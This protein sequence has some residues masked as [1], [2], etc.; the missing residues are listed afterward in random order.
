M[1][2]YTRSKIY[3]S[4]SNADGTETGTT[5][6]TQTTDSGEYNFQPLEVYAQVTQEQNVLTP[7]VVSVGTNNPDYNNIVSAKSIGGAVGMIPL[8]VEGDLPQI[9][10]ETDIKVKVNSAA[11]PVPATSPTLEFRIILSG[12]EM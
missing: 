1:S 11:V 10:G 8:Q 3:Y 7:A 6:I 12:L 9:P 2:L 4:E 5:L